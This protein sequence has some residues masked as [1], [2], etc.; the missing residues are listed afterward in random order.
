MLHAHVHRSS[1]GGVPSALSPPRV[2]G[3]ASPGRWWAV[4]PLLLLLT[5]AGL[6]GSL[7]AEEGGAAEALLTKAQ[8]YERS[9]AAEREPARRLELLNRLFQCYR[10][11]A[12]AGRTAEVRTFA[13]GAAKRLMEEFPGALETFQA[14]LQAARLNIATLDNA[15]PEEENVS[16]YEQAASALGELLGRLKQRL[17]EEERKSPP[18][19]RVVDQLRSLQRQAAYQA[20]AAQYSY[21]ATLDEGDPRRRGLLT[22]AADEFSRLAFTYRNT[23]TSLA[24]SVARGV[25]LKEAGDLPAAE[26]VLRRTLASP[27][28]QEAPGLRA[29]ASFHL[30]S[31]LLAQRRVSE[32]ENVAAAFRREFPAENRSEL[33]GALALSLARAYLAEA[34][35]VAEG[36][37]ASPQL[38]TWVR[39]SVRSAREVGPLDPAC[40]RDAADLVF[41][42]RRLS[43]RLVAPTAEEGL[44]RARGRFAAGDYEAA[45]DLYRKNVDEVTETVPAEDLARARAEFAV[46]LHRTG[47]FGEGLTILENLDTDAIDPAVRPGLMLLQ[48]DICQRLLQDG[49]DPALKDRRSRLLEN[50]RKE[51]PNSTAAT[52]A[53]LL[54]AQDADASGHHQEALRLLAHLE[55]D[56]EAKELVLVLEARCYWGLYRQGLADGAEAGKLRLPLDEARRR[57]EDV[58]GEGEEP[59]TELQARAAVALAGVYG[60]DLVA[61]HRAAVALADRVLAG[62]QP[63]LHRGALLAKVDALTKLAQLPRA[64]AV[65]DE[66]ARRFPRDPALPVL[67]LRL[68]QQW[69]R[70]ADPAAD[71]QSVRG[72]ARLVELALATPEQAEARLYLQA[73]RVLTAAG[74]HTKAAQVLSEG[75]LRAPADDQTVVDDLR[76]AAAKAYLD[77]GN[78][79]QAARILGGTDPTS[80]PAA[81]AFAWALSQEKLGRYPE[82][83]RVF[84]QLSAISNR[85]FDEW[86]D[87]R[88]HLALGLD[89]LGRHQEALE[90][91]VVSRKLYGDLARE[92]QLAA[93]SALEGQVRAKLTQGN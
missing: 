9:L 85:D 88:Y 1:L 15:Q 87:A 18:D 25:C 7:H 83:L 50:V 44:V 70:A 56:G 66:L 13:W 58:L 22:D 78:P 72:I 71:S 65:V 63:E 74:Q 6:P 45:A 27:Q 37:P 93:L 53:S 20:P 30:V 32:A 42:A 86:M 62:E 47:R 23:D 12:E 26:D 77:A 73:G 67:A 69:T 48:A 8:E 34:R 90:V 16:L 60:T 19:R 80:W 84:R 43:P 24:C 14:N 10:E 51:Y 91:L 75:L 59:L 79:D 2:G 92:G 36:D 89:R 17:A 82:S 55:K 40:G 4:I 57:L 64:A 61:D 3:G 49:Q 81:A 5:A 76:S 28:A 21:A 11:L 38:G 68:A 46:T 35:I 41:E 33:G 31:V 52:N 29:Q 54:L 39:K